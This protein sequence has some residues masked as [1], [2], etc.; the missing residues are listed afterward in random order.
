MPKTKQSQQ[1][2]EHT[3]GLPV[4]LKMDFPNQRVYGGL[5]NESSLKEGVVVTIAIKSLFDKLP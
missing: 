3:Y 2:P 1:K 5:T 4:L